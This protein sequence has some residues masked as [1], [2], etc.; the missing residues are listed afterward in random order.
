MTYAQSGASTSNG[1]RS[2]QRLRSWHGR[3]YAPRMRR[4]VQNLLDW[5]AHR[6]SPVDFFEKRYATTEDPWNLQTSSYELTK[7]QRTVQTVS[8]HRRGNRVL[9]VGC[10]EGVLTELLAKLGMSVVAVDLS[11]TAVARARRRCAPYPQVILL[12]RDGSL[13]ELPERFD[14]IVL[15][16]ILY[17]F[18]S[19]TRAQLSQRL[20]DLLV[21]GGHVVAVNPWPRSRRV[22]REL[23]SHPDLF[24]VEENVHAEPGRPYAITTYRRAPRNGS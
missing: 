24:V 18:D 14:L 17:Y 16:E 22:E 7:L 13:L 8:R 6:R 21:N 3:R 4:V 12:T 9:D 19:P 11:E 23:S 1:R 2:R 5:A 15:S 20:I 10:G